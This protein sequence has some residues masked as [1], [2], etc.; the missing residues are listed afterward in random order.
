MNHA[1]GLWWRPHPDGEAYGFR[2]DEGAD[3]VELSHVVPREQRHNVYNA[4][5]PTHVAPDG[6]LLL[7]AH[8]GHLVLSCPFDGGAAREVFRSDQK[9][10]DFAVR[11]DGA[12]VLSLEGEIAVRERDPCSP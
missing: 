5:L 11:P 2:R 1:R 10:L 6:G 9:I 12:L 3:P 4:K 8:A 7:D